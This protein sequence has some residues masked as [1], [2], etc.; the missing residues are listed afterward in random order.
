MSQTLDG[1]RVL[2]VDDHPAVCEG[3]RA[4]MLAEPDLGFGKRRQARLKAP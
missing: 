1:K 3:L 4:L 2:L